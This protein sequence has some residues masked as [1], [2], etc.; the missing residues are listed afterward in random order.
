MIIIIA[1]KSDVEHNKT[2]ISTLILC[3]AA[4]SQV[5]FVSLPHGVVSRSQ[6]AFFPFVCGWGQWW[7][8]LQDR[9]CKVVQQQQ[10]KDFE[11]PVFLEILKDSFLTVY[12]LR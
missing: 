12:V 6:T 7:S 9:D 3:T 4:A 11:C 8:F 10:E 2:L 1:C 5:K